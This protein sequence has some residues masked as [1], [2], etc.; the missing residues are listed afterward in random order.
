MPSEPDG[1][2]V[3]VLAAVLTVLTFL[4]GFVSIRLH[5]A[6]REALERQR[7]L[8]LQLNSGRGEFPVSELENAYKNVQRTLPDTLATPVLAVLVVFTALGIYL[9]VLTARAANI[10][11]FD[12]R[13]PE[14]FYSLALLALA[15]VAVTALVSVDYVR[16]R[17]R[18][19]SARTE[20]AVH[21]ILRAEELIGT[22][23]QDMQRWE[24]ASRESSWATYELAYLRGTREN[25]EALLTQLNNV[26]D[27]QR[28]AEWSHRQT[29]LITLLESI[30]KSA[31]KWT[32]LKEQ[33]KRKQASVDSNTVLGLPDLQPVQKI[34]D[35]LA[36]RP[37]LGD[38]G[39]IDG[40]RAVA[41]L[42]GSYTP[43]TGRCRL[44]PTRTTETEN[45]LRSACDKEPG[46]QR[47]H[48]AL[49]FL[50]EELGDFS[51]AA[52]QTI[53]Q[54][55]LFTKALQ[56]PSSVLAPTE[57]RELK[58]LALVFARKP[59]TYRAACDTT[60]LAG[61]W[62]TCSFLIEQYLRT[63]L[64][65]AVSDLDRDAFTPVVDYIR[66][67]TAGLC[68]DKGQL[69]W[70]RA[71]QF[72][73]RCRTDIAKAFPTAVGFVDLKP[74]IDRIE[75]ELVEPRRAAWNDAHPEPGSSID[76]V[77]NLHQPG[78]DHQL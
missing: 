5:D 35:T 18:L 38:W 42:V 56:L 15:L 65:T 47:W 13:A 60:R 11:W 36:T 41:E 29:S 55:Q 9:A 54:W 24:I 30:D 78:S 74:E 39:H 70:W 34:L 66:Q 59:S 72:L 12:N 14:R 69:G 58:K 33:A 10:R 6:Y 2:A 31:A 67:A 27:Q 20:S 73:E 40:L 23:W 1:A 28:N 22:V 8:D 44:N 43:A 53:Q 17:W 19:R 77:T 76:K 63:M 61:D 45:W 25:T 37:G 32:S 26:P 52:D 21:Q 75:D 50:K 4:S 48:G 71:Q 51:S 64:A 49:A 62:I 46:Q 7:Q 16:L 57:V 3:A 68:D